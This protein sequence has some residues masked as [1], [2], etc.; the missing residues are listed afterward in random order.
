[1]EYT[2]IRITT[3]CTSNQKQ[4]TRYFGEYSGGTM[5]V[6]RNFIRAG[7][8]NNRVSTFRYFWRSLFL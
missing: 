7:E 1:M 5:R 3:Y 4:T 8:N 6:A 2:A